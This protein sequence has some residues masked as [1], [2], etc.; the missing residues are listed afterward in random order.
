MQRDSVT[1]RV[2]TAQKSKNKMKQ[3]AQMKQ[4]KLDRVKQSSKTK[5]SSRDDALEFW[6]SPQL[7]CSWNF[8]RF[9]STLAVPYL[10]ILKERQR[11]V[12]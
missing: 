6:F 2:A 11:R 3:G 5:Q 12:K 7:I 10:G 4:R 1:L 8:S 9:P